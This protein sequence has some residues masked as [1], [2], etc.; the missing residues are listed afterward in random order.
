MEPARGSNAPIYPMWGGR[1]GIHEWVRLSSITFADD[2]TISGISSRNRSPCNRRDGP[3]TL[4]APATSPF[5]V[6]IGAAMHRKPSSRSSRS[7]ATP[8]FRTSYSSDL[9]REMSVIVLSV[10]R[11]NPWVEAISSTRSLGT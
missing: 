1:R 6:S 5:G 8:L 7:K 3:E 2:W 11:G 9:S 10:P 4:S